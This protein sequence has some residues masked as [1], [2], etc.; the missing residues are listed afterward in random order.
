[1]YSNIVVFFLR[2]K[3]P[4]TSHEA[5]E[6]VFTSQE[7]QDDT[8]PVGAVGFLFG[9]RRVSLPARSVS[10]VHEDVPVGTSSHDDDDDDDVSR[11]RHED[12]WV[13]RFSHDDDDND[14]FSL[15][16]HEDVSVGRFPDS[17]AK[18]VL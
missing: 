17:P 15:G 16:R 18:S 11:G 1:M 7:K 2:K 12:V 10:A 6:K 3:N 9:D 5:E 14:D 8:A 4:A 13:G